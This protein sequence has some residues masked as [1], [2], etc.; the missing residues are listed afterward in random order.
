[1]L[2]REDIPVTLTCDGNR[3]KEVNMIKHTRGF[4]WGAGGTSTAVWK[5]VPLR[6]ILNKCGVGTICSF[7]LTLRRSYKGKICAL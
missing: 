6:L 4:S 7:F 3:R 2:T 5:G 1:M